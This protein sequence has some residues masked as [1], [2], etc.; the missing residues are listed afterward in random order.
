MHVCED[1]II[2]SWI[3]NSATSH[4]PGSIENRPEQEECEKRKERGGQLK[5]GGEVE[6]L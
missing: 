1:K 6:E 2:Y 3:A 4:W 5:G